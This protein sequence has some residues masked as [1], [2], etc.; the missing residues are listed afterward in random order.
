MNL[1]SDD[2]DESSSEK[3][4]GTNPSKFFFLNKTQDFASKPRREEPQPQAAAAPHSQNELP[5][6]KQA[7]SNSVHERS[8][9]ADTENNSNREQIGSQTSDL[10]ISPTALL[11]GEFSRLFAPAEAPS[12]DRPKPASPSKGFEMSKFKEMSKMKGFKTQVFESKVAKPET[13]PGHAS[14]QQ[15]FSRDVQMAKTCKKFFER[16]IK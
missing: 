15:D 7:V 4:V 13:L 11:T 5:Q 1:L 8:E 12:E 3:Q 9:P 6:V 16:M 10:K 2:D 14:S